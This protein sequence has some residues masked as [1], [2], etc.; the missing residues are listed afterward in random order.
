MKNLRA[1][2]CRAKV[3]TWTNDE[4]HM[5][6]VPF[7]CLNGKWQPVGC[8]TKAGM[9]SSDPKFRTMFPLPFDWRPGPRLL[10]RLRR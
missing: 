5:V 9:S 10:R 6:S 3:L 2:E 1:M 4:G 7:L 8:F